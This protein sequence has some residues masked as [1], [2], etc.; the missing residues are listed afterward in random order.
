MKKY[1][2]KSIAGKGLIFRIGIFFTMPGWYI[3]RLTDLKHINL[4]KQATQTVWNIPFFFVFVAWG[5]FVLFEKVS[6]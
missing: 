1:F 6:F 4:L 3:F 2:S 5:L